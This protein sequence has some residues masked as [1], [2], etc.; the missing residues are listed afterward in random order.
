MPDLGKLYH[1][2][3]Q[4]FR[5]NHL[6]SAEAKPRALFE[7]DA[8]VATT[9]EKLTVGVS[10]EPLLTLPEFSEM[11]TQINALRLSECS[12]QDEI[13]GRQVLIKYHRAKSSI[14]LPLAT[15]EGN[16]QALRYTQGMRLIA[17]N[18]ELT[19]QASFKQKILKLFNHYRQQVQ[20]VGYE[21]AAFELADAYALLLKDEFKLSKSKAKT[22]VTMARDLSVL[23]NPHIDIC[24]ISESVNQVTIEYAKPLKISDNY[25]EAEFKNLEE[26]VWYRDA[27]KVAGLKNNATW[28]DNFF[29]N[30]FEALKRCGV[31]APPSSRWLPLP[32]NSQEL[33]SKVI[34][35]DEKTNDKTPLE[36]LPS[37]QTHLVRLGTVTAYELF[38]LKEQKRIAKNI[39]KEILQQLLAAEIA[40]FKSTYDGLIDETPEFFINYQTLLTPHFFE[41]YGYRFKAFIPFLKDNNAEFVSITKKAMAELQKEFH[42]VGMNA[43]FCYTNAAVNDKSEWL[44]AQNSNVYNKVRE[45]KLLATAKILRNVAHQRL[46]PFSENF[47]AKLTAMNHNKEMILP[48]PAKCLL[49]VSLYISGHNRFTPSVAIEMEFVAQA[50]EKGELLKDYNLELQ[51]ELALRMRSSFHLRQCISGASHFDDLPTMQRNIMMASLEA[52]VLGKQALTMMGC[53]SARDRMALMAGA[54]K[55]QQENPKGM[56]RWKMLFD[57][58][59]NSIHTGHH[60]RA[61]AYH[62]EVVKAKDVAKEFFDALRKPLQNAITRTAS[63]VKKLSN[64]SDRLRKKL[65]FIPI[66]N[67][68][69]FDTKKITEMVNK[70]VNPEFR[71]TPAVLPSRSP[72]LLPRSPAS[73]SARPKSALLRSAM[74]PSAVSK[75]ALPASAVHVILDETPRGLTI[76]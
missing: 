68:I 12:H 60:F 64:Y 44:I 45:E 5:T 52:H 65:S 46:K 54:I 14:D 31:G 71:T 58:I 2:A 48:S 38:D 1:Q 63:F 33:Y 11:Q 49:D 47:K 17:E 39:L 19:L 66:S 29:A 26:K 27:K 8:L 59:I 42:V 75:P 35:F 28:L 53:K 16:I 74:F 34:K 20:K 25:Y 37:T 9:L 41:K 4:R 30:N 6:I 10:V 40:Q 21:C 67:I 7:P 73:G 69:G 43:K 56:Y 55:T 18:I 3:K 32:A 22:Q 62:V 24:T 51:N 23:L 76:N 50:L 36:S 57:G 61:M 13:D 70:K 15:H 72:V